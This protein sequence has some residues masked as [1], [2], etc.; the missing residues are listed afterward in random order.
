MEGDSG[1]QVQ[2][3]YVT[4]QEESQGSCGEGRDDGGRQEVRME[5][6]SKLLAEK[7][8]TAVQRAV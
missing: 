4:R 3:V 5:P 6:A 1:G 2:G 8:V 7:R